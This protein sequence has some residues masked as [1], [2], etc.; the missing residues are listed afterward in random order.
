MI[1]PRAAKFGKT[2]AGSKDADFYSLAK[3][4]L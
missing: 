4:A 2:L 3:P 1:L